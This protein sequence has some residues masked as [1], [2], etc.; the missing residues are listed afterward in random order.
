MTAD[1][2]HFTDYN[3]LGV[4]RDLQIDPELLGLDSAAERSTGIPIPNPDF[5]LGK[6]RGK[7]ILFPDFTLEKKTT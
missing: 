7:T 4:Y 6:G 3:G 1:L 2:Q 5:K